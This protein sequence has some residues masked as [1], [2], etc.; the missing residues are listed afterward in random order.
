[1]TKPDWLLNEPPRRP[2]NAQMTDS[3]TIQSTEKDQPAAPKHP[4]AELKP[5]RF[6][7]EDGALRFTI[8]CLIALAL[9]QAGLLIWMATR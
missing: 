7:R 2:R 8:V 5:D 3:E 1:M 6:R 4:W 9:F